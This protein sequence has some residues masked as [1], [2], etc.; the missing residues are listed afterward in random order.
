MQESLPYPKIVPPTRVSFCSATSTQKRLRLSVRFAWR[1][2]W[3]RPK[4]RTVFGSRNVAFR[5]AA[6][7]ASPARNASGITVGAGSVWVAS[8]IRPAMIFRHDPLTGHCT[9]FILLAGEGG[10][11]GLQ[12]RP[13]ASDE[14]PPASAAVGPELHPTAP[15]GRRNAGPGMS[16]TLW[17]SRPGRSESITWTLRWATC[18]AR[19]PFPRRARTACSGMSAMAP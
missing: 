17:V 11:H 6:S 12:W 14:H 18:L 7:F 2:S 5:S 10:V 8:N 19:C 13:Y 15:A 16:G 1:N 3:I 9:A 4:P